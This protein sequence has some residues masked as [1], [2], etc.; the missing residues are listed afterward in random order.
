MKLQHRFGCI[1]SPKDDRDF[2]VGYYLPP[3]TLPLKTSYRPR[4][5]PVK[6]QGQLGSCVAFACN[7][8]D[9]YCH[10]VLDLSEMWTYD[11]CKRLDGLRLEGTYPR[12]GMQ[13]LKNKGVCSEV[14]WRYLDRYPPET[15]PAPGADIDALKHRISTYAFVS[16]GEIRQALAAH[17]PLLT[18]HWVYENYRDSFA[19]GLWPAPEGLNL[20]G[21]AVLLCGYDDEKQ[22]FEIKGSWSTSVGDEGY[23]YMPY[24]AMEKLYIEAWCGVA[25]D[26][27]A[28]RWSD[29]PP[30]DEEDLLAHDRVYQLGVMKG[31]ADKHGRPDGTFHPHEAITRH[32]VGTIMVR[33]GLLKTNPWNEPA[34]WREPALRGWVHER[35]PELHFREERWSE[36]LT[37]FQVML[38]VGRCLVYGLVT[39]RKIEEV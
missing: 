35:L 12:I 21:H 18:A 29:L 20:G 39:P 6:Y 37:R 5:S 34:D 28:P 22:L 4:L 9:E 27:I 2:R 25:P 31:W 16:F 19:T 36:P 7:G 15:T 17:G 38:L 32:Q 1:P 3:T 10:S 13:V 11:W 23:F 24:D 33:L 14:Y 30:M 26:K 8:L